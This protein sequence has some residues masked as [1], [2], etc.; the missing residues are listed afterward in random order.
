MKRRRIAKKQGGVCTTKSTCN[1]HS[2]VH[3]ARSSLCGSLATRFSTRVLPSHTMPSIAAWRCSLMQFGTGKPK[4]AILDIEVVFEVSVGIKAM[5]RSGYLKR[6]VSLG[7]GHGDAD[8]G[9][10]TK[11]TTTSSSSRNRSRSCG[12]DCQDS[13]LVRA[14]CGVGCC[15]ESVPFLFSSAKRTRAAQQTS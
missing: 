6:V 2:K 14:Y 13:I 3:R 8:A 7:S 11:T 4:L 9:C 15:V 5:C 10:E 1:D 12:S